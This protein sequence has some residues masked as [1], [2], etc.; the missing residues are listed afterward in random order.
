MKK[1]VKTIVGASLVLAGIVFSILPGSILFVLAGLLILATEFAIARV[2]LRKCQSGMSHGARR[3]DR[4]LLL[5]K[6]R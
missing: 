4:F 3:L 2:W 1:T 5:R 6:L